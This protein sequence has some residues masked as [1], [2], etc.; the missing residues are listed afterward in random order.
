MMNNPDCLQD[1][2]Y[3]FQSSRIHTCKTTG[4]PIRRIFANPIPLFGRL[5][6]EDSTDIQK[7]HSNFYRFKLINFKDNAY[8]NAHV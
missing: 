4:S 2:I 5:N 1:Q 3:A 6:E 8:L 7:D